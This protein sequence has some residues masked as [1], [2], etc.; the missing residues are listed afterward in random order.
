MKLDLD[1][2]SNLRVIAGVYESRPSHDIELGYLLF[3]RM[4]SIVVSVFSNLEGQSIARRRVDVLWPCSS[5][6]SS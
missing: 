4:M 2:I 5:I 3:S 6:P 1:L